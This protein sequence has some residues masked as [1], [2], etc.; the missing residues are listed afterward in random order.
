MWSDL[1]DFTNGFWLGGTGGVVIQ[2]GSFPSPVAVQSGVVSAGVAGG[3]NDAADT[4]TTIDV[5][6]DSSGW[7]QEIAVDG[8]TVVTAAGFLDSTY[9][10]SERFV[11]YP[12]M[13]LTGSVTVEDITFH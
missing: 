11:C 5:Q 2:A 3:G 10:E 4:V 1:N 12:E 13:Y 9:E 8:R 7:L 6:F